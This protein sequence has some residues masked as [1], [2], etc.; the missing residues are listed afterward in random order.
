MY[1]KIR[2][3]VMSLV[4][5]SIVMLSSVGTLSYFT[6]TDEATNNFL[7]GNA[8]TELKIYSDDAGENEFVVPAE[9]LEDGTEIAF[10]PQATNTGNIPVF[11]RFRVVIPIGLEDVVTPKLPTDDSC[12]VK[13]T[14]THTCSNSDYTIIYKPYDS[15][16]NTP[17]EYD[18][19]SNNILALGS[20]TSRWPMTGIKFGDISSID[21]EVYTCANGDRNNCMFGVNIY[22]DVMQ[23]T[24]S[25]NG[26]ISAF[27]NF[28]VTNN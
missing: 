16:A 8:A 28:T 11:Q 23:T 27:E 9:A 14:E 5:M 12:A 18:I 22:S 19:V 25:I 10:Y 7:V 13:T 20:K 4:V 24:G 3:T 26:A 2:I 15:E 6:D 21:S 17:A 1:R